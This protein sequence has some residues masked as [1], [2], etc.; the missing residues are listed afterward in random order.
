MT[1]INTISITS[2]GVNSPS[3]SQPIFQTMAL[4]SEFTASN[5]QYVATSSQ[6]PITNVSGYK[7][8]YFQFA[9][10]TVSSSLG[11]S[12]F[13]V[14]SSIDGNTWTPVISS[15]FTG[16]SQSI[17]TLTGINYVQVGYS[18]VSGSSGSA[19]VLGVY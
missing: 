13:T 8:Y 3:Y 15:K 2:P 17:Y 12:S 6:T 4:L 16:V 11:T 7:N 9:T 5:G 14:S 18:Q 10:N 19:Y 1:T